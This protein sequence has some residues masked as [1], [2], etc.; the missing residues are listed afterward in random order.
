[1]SVGVKKGL[2][3]TDAA[4]QQA[5]KDADAFVTN[6]RERNAAAKLYEAAKAGLKAWLGVETSRSLPDGRTVALTVVPTTGYVV[7]DG[8]KATLTVTSPPPAAE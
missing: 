3:G 4:T 8:T 1:M 6:G 7:A 2:K 5:M